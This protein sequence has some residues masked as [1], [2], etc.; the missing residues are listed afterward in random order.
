MSGDLYKVNLAFFQRVWSAKLYGFVDLSKSKFY[1]QVEMAGDA[2]GLHDIL[3]S[4]DCI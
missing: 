1:I 4:F 2:A 3:Q